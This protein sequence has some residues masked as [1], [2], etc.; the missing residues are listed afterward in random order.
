[1]KPILPTHRTRILALA[2]ASATLA[3]TLARADVVDCELPEVTIDKPAAGAM[4]EGDEIA[5]TLTVTGVGTQ[6]ALREAYVLVDGT[7]AKSQ[8][9]EASGTYTLQVPVSA[10]QH[11]LIGGA[12]D[13]CAGET[14]SE[15]I[16]ITVAAAADGSSSGEGG[17]AGDGAP[18]DDD[19]KGGCSVDTVP[20]RSWVGFSALLLTVLGVS[21]LRRRAA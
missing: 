14:K 15:P 3:P 8:A 9:I 5:V 1:M 20:T 17:S 7:K 18:A 16:N 19:D 4:L 12:V 11:A 13:D 2:F 10:G 6:Q 21:R